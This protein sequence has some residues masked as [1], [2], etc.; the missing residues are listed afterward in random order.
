MKM[1]DFYLSASKDG[2]P[3]MTEYFMVTSFRAFNG[4]LSKCLNRKQS[5]F[6]TRRAG[7]IHQQSVDVF[8]PLAME[9]Y[10]VT[11]IV[12]QTKPEAQHDIS[13]GEP[14]NF[15]LDAAL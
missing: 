9:Y 7:A 5:T 6:F 10:A 4:D 3:E 15:R 13:K 12:M 14:P 11:R 1:G 8:G 2:N